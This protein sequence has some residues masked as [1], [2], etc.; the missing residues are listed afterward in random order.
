MD[1]R[2]PAQ[3][4]VLTVN[5]GTSSIRLGL[6]AHDG[7][8][9]WPLAETRYPWRGE[10]APPL[11]RRFLREHA[12]EDIETVAHRVVHGGSALPPAVVID[13]AVERE[14]ERLVPLAPLHNPIA[15]VWL[16][17][18]REVIGAGPVHAAVFDTG[19]YRTLPPVA[20]AYALP[21]ALIEKHGL[22]RFG[23]HGLAHAYMNRRWQRHGPAGRVISLQLGAG[24]SITATA[25]G[26]ARDTSM[27]FTPLEGLVMATRSGDLDPGL[28]LF[29]QQVESW[30]ACHA[31]RV[32]NEEAGL[33]G[34]SGI[35]G[36]MR[37][38]L[39]SDDP[40]ARLAV[41]LYCYRARKYIGAYMAAL[42]GVDAILFGG[43]VG[44]NAPAV[45]ERILAGMEWCG[46]RIDPNRNAATGVERRISADD[47]RV[48]VWAIPVN[49]AAM[50]AEQAVAL[51]AGVPVSA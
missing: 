46:I 37:A 18:A 21:G 38:L 4:T 14:I 43:G 10:P 48:A 33:A 35:S 26:R 17:A 39:D 29:L 2:N 25:Q 22:R 9:V 31:D 7:A 44:E 41:D 19:F 27:G 5:A 42:G 45:R 36:D 32:L 28:L 51:R 23:F 13:D 20:Q 1:T 34:L 24:C 30:D 11:L 16:R 15:L 3:P 49:E 50:L 12:V 8:E 6:F 47:A 40:R